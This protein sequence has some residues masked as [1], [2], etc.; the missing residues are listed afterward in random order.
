MSKA[1]M[2]Q[3]ALAIIGVALMLSKLDES[4]SPVLFAVGVTFF[5][6]AIFNIIILT[7]DKNRIYKMQMAQ[8]LALEIL[9]AHTNVRLDQSITINFSRVDEKIVAEITHKFSYSH[10]NKDGKNCIVEIFSDHKGE[11]KSAFITTASPD[12][13]FQEVDG[14]ENPLKWDAVSKNIVEDRKRLYCLKNGKL[15]LKLNSAYPNGDEHQTFKFVICNKYN[16]SDRLFWSFQEMSS[17]KVTIKIVTDKTIKNEKFYIRV[18]HHCTER[19]IKT[20]NEIS[21]TKIDTKTGL[22]CGKEITL[23]INENI[24]PYQSF[25]LTW[26]VPER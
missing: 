23:V 2:I 16:L 13:Y 24:L 22:I 12:F 8:D 1:K 18:N 10:E 17:G 15:Y 19:I 4:L 25:E 11:D 21:P 7:F 6:T 14:E 5:A 26:D 20:H 9:G 3:I